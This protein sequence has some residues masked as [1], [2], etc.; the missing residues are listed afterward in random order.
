[1][2]KGSNTTTT[3]Q[4]LSPEQQQLLSYALP[5]AKNIS[6]NTPTQFPG[7]SVSGFD[8]LQTQAQ[9]L[10]AATAT[11]SIQPLVDSTIATQQ[12]LQSS[13]IPQGVGG[14]GALV[15]GINKATPAQDFFLSGQ[16]MDP[17]SNPYIQRTA[18]AA[19]DPLQ[20]TLTQSILPSIRRGATGAGQTGSSRQGIAEGLAIQDFNKQAGDITSRIF[21]DSYSQG[22]G[23]TGDALRSTLGLAK[24]SASTLL[25][26]GT[27]SL[28]ATPEIGNLALLPSKILSSVGGQKQ[29]QSQAV[30]SDEAARYMQEQLMPFLVAQDVANL[31]FGIPNG[32]TISTTSSSGPNPLQLLLGTGSMLA[33]LPGLGF[34]K[35]YTYDCFT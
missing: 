22:L 13:A 5:A 30:L 21:S 29:Q 2:A 24:D 1:M 4:E 8:P 16:A 23:A 33:G 15:G 27:R 11:G 35:G 31:A 17:T 28:F 12:N 26:Q 3:K 20:K 32:S 10:A 6:E 19:I 18:E 25:D 14:L 7:G 9:D 34:Q